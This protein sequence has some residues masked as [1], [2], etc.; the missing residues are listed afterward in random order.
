VDTENV[1]Q[2]IGTIRLARREFKLPQIRCLVSQPNTNG[3]ICVRVRGGNRLIV[4][5]LSRIRAQ[6][7]PPNWGTETGGRVS[8]NPITKN[9]YVMVRWIGEQQDN[10]C[11]IMS[12]THRI[13]CGPFGG[14]NKLL[15][16]PHWIFSVD[17]RKGTATRKIL[18]SG[19][20]EHDANP[21]LVCGTCLSC[22]SN[23]GRPGILP[24]GIPPA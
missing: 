12:L 10:V 7:S 4:T 11:P 23:S 24:H 5:N 16:S 6:L 18:I 1:P 2:L 15:I 20:G 21:V 8:S 9:C 14:R 13:W 17:V 22:L 19:V 3:E